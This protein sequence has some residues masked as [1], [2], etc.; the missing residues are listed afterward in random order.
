MIDSFFATIS[1]SILANFGYL[2]TLDEVL[3]IDNKY[4]RYIGCIVIVLLT[5]YA[6]LKGV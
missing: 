3:N 2:F 4:I 1:I 5:G 6:C